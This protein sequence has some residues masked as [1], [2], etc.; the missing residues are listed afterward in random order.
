[1]QLSTKQFN[2]CALEGTYN[3]GVRVGANSTLSFLL[4]TAFVGAESHQRL[5]VSVVGSIQ[6]KNLAVS[7]HLFRNLESQ[8]IGLC[9]VCM[10]VRMPSLLKFNPQ[11]STDMRLAQS[12]C[13]TPKM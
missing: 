6:H 4:L 5:A 8:V 7:R 10:R 9:T 12:K 13:P 2:Y 3:P 1:M 11:R